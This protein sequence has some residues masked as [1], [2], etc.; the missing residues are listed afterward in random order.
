MKTEKMVE[1]V[2][3]IKMPQN[4]QERI[5][6]N[7]QKEVEVNYMS[8]N[9]TKSLFK[10]PMVAVAALALCFCLTGVTALAATGK[11]QGFFKDIIGW[12]GAVTGTSYEQAT[13]EIEMSIVE[14]SDILT[15]ELEMVNPDVAPYSVFDTFGIKEYK[16]MDADG[17]VIAE[18]K[19][20][21]MVEMTD[22]KVNV[23]IA[24][25]GVSS[26][27]YKLVVKKLVGSAKADQPLEISGTWECTFT[28]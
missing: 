6:N 19:E 16:I 28:R 24:L 25:D 21:E 7:C 3:D 17:D 13:D 4:M 18:N 11:L 20:T 22:G 10:R 1:A 26:G 8:K 12:N 14:V 15:V 9:T 23:C 2:K 27:E 5:I